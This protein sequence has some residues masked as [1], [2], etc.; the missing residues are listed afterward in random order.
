MQFDVEQFVPLFDEEHG[1]SVVV[2]GVIEEY[3]PGAEVLFWKGMYVEVVDVGA[4]LI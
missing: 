4:V 3:F 1:L 2:V